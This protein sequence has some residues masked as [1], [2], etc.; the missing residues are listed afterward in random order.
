MDLSTERCD[1]FRKV[2][3]EHRRELDEVVGQ[4]AEHVEG[5]TGVTPSFAAALEI[6]SRRGGILSAVPSTT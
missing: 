4:D 3:P 1:V 5:G 2:H 6:S